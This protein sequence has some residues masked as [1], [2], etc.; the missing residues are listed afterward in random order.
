ML[1][2]KVAEIECVHENETSPVMKVIIFLVYGSRK[3]KE[4]VDHEFKRCSVKL[5][6]KNCCI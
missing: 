4:A 3:S 1:L 6:Y 2:I 5:T